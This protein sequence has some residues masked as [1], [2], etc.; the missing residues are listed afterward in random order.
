VPVLSFGENEVYSTVQLEQGSFGRR[1]QTALQARLGFA[2]PL[3]CGRGFMPL[4]PR[5]QLVSSIIGA[6]LRPP[7]NAAADGNG[8]T[9]E[10][11]LEEVDALHAKYCEALSAMF[12]EHK[13]AH[14]A[15]NMELEI[16]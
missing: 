4:L 9:V 16:V 1:I 7:K 5:R 13:A 6:P 3:F 10:P 11:T 14:G 12:K 2:L 15:E 8:K